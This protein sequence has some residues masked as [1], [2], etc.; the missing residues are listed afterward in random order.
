MEPSFFFTSLLLSWWDDYSS[1]SLD[2]NWRKQK[3]III[4]FLNVFLKK[5][6]G[7]WTNYK[8]NHY[9]CTL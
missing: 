5:N 2:I 4:R 9:I 7:I 6:K 3:H 8:K 1:T